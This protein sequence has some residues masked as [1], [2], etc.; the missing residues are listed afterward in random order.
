MSLWDWL[1][2]AWI[3][4]ELFDDD[5]DSTLRNNTRDYDSSFDYDNY[6]EDY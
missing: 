3:Y 6:E 5:S 2:A 1:L 4:E